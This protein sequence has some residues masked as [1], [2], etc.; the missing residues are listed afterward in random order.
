MLLEGILMEFFEEPRNLPDISGISCIDRVYTLH[1]DALPQEEFQL[2]NITWHQYLVDSLIIRSAPTQKAAAAVLIS[3]YCLRNQF[4]QYYRLLYLSPS[5]LFASRTL[6]QDPSKSTAICCYQPSWYV[7][8]LFP[9]L[10]FL[11]I[12]WN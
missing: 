1:S 7:K 2:S 8:L 4:Y 10:T 11:N 9:M 5:Y 12:S 6:L 3:H